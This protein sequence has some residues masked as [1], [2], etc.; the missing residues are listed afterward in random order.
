[1]T[2][3]SKRNTINNNERFYS[4]NVAGGAEHGVRAIRRRHGVTFVCTPLTS[5]LNVLKSYF[6][7]IEFVIYFDV[8]YN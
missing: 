4:Q 3:H 7:S 6:F 5:R 8:F 2:L 1:M